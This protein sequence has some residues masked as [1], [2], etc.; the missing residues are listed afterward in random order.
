MCDARGFTVKWVGDDSA[1]AYPA[2]SNQGVGDG[3]AR[4]RPAF[5]NEPDTVT[6]L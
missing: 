5:S 6:G 1:I 3:R 4:A 2:S